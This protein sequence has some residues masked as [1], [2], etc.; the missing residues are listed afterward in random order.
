MACFA[1]F[2]YLK[3]NTLLVMLTSKWLTIAASLSLREAGAMRSLR[4]AACIVV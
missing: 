1:A 2:S 3:C 4:Q